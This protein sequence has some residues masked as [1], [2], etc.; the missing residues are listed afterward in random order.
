MS[1]YRRRL[2]I[3]SLFAAF[4]LPTSIRAEVTQ[5]EITSK[6][7]FGT[8]RPGDYVIWQGRVAVII[9]AAASSTA[10]GPLPPSPAPR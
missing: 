10:F 4:L 7:P 3:A 8:F 1:R 2:L 9:Q 5:L 6:Q